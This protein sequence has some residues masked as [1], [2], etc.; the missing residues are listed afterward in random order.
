MNPNHNT[1]YPMTPRKRIRKK[2]PTTFAALTG[3]LN[4]R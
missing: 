3:Y 4:I 2:N 1:R